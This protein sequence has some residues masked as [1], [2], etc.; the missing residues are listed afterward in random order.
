LKENKNIVLVDDHIIIRN[1]LKE[2]IEKLGD[3]TIT[4]QF[5]NGKA[6]IDALPL[7]PKPHL[8]VMDLSM[9]EMNGNEAMIKLK[10]LQ[11][12]LP[13]LILTL[14]EE[15]DLIL[16]LFRLGVRGYLKKNC[17]AIE[18]QTALSEIFRCGYYHNEFLALSLQSDT[19]PTKKT[20]QQLILDQLTLREKE[21]LKLVCHEKEYTYEQIADKMGVQHRTVDGYRESLF[22]KFSIKSKTGLVLFVLKHK[23]FD[24]L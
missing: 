5:D 24:S 13:V 7:M 1:G 6:F 8:I 19:A 11:I 23:L 3:Y 15:E 21:F 12:T 4:Q 16:K 18:L 22:E 14:N 9:P 10:S 2:L 20:E 17:T